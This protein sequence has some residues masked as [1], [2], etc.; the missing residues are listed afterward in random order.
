MTAASRIAVRRGTGLPQVNAVVGITQ[1]LLSAR[2]RR[3]VPCWVG[4]LVP[5][6]RWTDHEDLRLAS[7]VPRRAE[8]MRTPAGGHVATVDVRRDIGQPKRHEV[9]GQVSHLQEPTANVDGAEKRDDCGH[10]KAWM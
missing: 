1:E 3:R 8:D 7:G 6:S 4:C 2:T 9:T 10:G 5:L